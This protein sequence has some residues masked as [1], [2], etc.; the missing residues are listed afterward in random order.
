MR[1]VVKLGGSLLTDV[2][3]LH[4]II[5]QLTEVQDRK[6]D[7]IVVHGGG[8]Q[9]KQ[10]LEQLKISS[11]FRNGLRV[12][13][14]ATMQ[15]VQMVLAG[16]VNKDIVA[17]F[18]QN[19]RAAVGLCGGDGRSFIA[20]KFADRGTQPGN[21]D[22]G[23]VG[24]IVQGNPK[25][26]N[27]LLSEGYFPVI[28]C[29]GLG[30][31]AAYYNVNADEMAAAVAIFCKAERL[32]FLTDV[33]GVLDAEKKVIPALTPAQMEKLRASAVISEGM[34]PKTRA[35]E[36]ALEHGIRQIHIVSGKAQDCLSRLLLQG[37]SMGTTIFH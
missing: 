8:Q 36:R 27:L 23:F 34:L 6:H 24:E 35:C 20:R 22:Y 25:L 14:P 4:R 15:V 28:A 1:I 29:I 30:E 11:H 13:D 9:I 10:Y 19:H 12:T 26:V 33:P 21:F 31:E 16:L 18:A 3:L 5:A 7:V 17:A 2:E 37:E 32:I